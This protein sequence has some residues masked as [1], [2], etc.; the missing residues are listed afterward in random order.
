LAGKR[1]YENTTLVK[2]K[3]IVTL[4]KVIHIISNIL[5]LVTQ[6]QFTT[7]IGLPSAE[8]IGHICHLGLDV[9]VCN[10]LLKEFIHL[11]KSTYTYKHI[12]T[13]YAG[14]QYYKMKRI[15]QVVWSSGIV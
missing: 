7:K 5:I 4:Y 15:V 14:R 6:P 3:L 12:C 13:W 11:K 2:F 9:Y 1:R 10:A 8:K